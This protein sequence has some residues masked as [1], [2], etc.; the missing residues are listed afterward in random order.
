VRQKK[1]ISLPTKRL[2]FLYP[3]AIVRLCQ[4]GEIRRRSGEKA[5]L[6]DRTHDGTKEDDRSHVD[7][8]G[9]RKIARGMAA[10]AFPSEGEYY[11][12]S[13]DTEIYNILL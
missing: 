13:G 7:A 10:P 9:Q 12:D 8:F 3:I 4:A 11:L 5:D 6:K 1:Y 2:F